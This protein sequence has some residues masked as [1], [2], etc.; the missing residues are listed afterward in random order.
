MVGRA[1]STFRRGLWP[2]AVTHA[3]R[4]VQWV[5]KKAT[6]DDFVKSL[7][8]AKAI[9]VSKPCRIE[10][11]P[12]ERCDTA[13]TIVSPEG[14]EVTSPVHLRWKPAMKMYVELW[15]R[16]GR[17]KGGEMES[18]TTLSLPTGTYEL[19][20]RPKRGFTCLSSMWF[21]VIQ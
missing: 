3:I 18:D 19:K 12:D 17:I 11:Q 21:N 16:G 5:V 6:D 2:T 20:V 7:K 15:Q 4:I 1:S 8:A 13:P 9:V 14:Q 10:R